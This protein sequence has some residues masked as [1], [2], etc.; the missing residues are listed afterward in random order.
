MN[1]QVNS[2]QTIGAAVAAAIAATA[3]VAPAGA[4]E[5][6]GS[7]AGRYVTGDFHNHSPCSDGQI[8]VQ[9][10]VNKSVDTYGLDWFVM[11]GHGGGGT[12]NCLL[13]EDETI[14]T[15][16]SNPYVPGQGPTTT[17]AN[18]IGIDKVKGD[19]AA[20]GFMFRWQSIQEFQYPVLEQMAAMKGKAIFIG[21]ESVVAGHE[22]S[23]V[24]VIDGQLPQGG[25]GN[26]TAM[27]QWEYCFDRADTD[28]SRG[29]GQ[30]WDCSVPGSELNADQDPT[31]AKLRNYNGKN[32]DS[33]T[34][35]HLKTVQG[36][37]WM[38][39]FHPRS[40]YYIPAHLER[41]GAFNPSSNRG[42]NVEHLRDFNNAAPDIAFGFEGGPGHQAS[43]SRGGYGGGAVGGG[44]YGG[45]GFYTAQVGGVWDALLGEGRNWF[46]FNNSDYHNR[47]SFGPDDP[48]T[49]NDQYPGEYNKTYVLARTGGAPLSPLAIIDGM[50]SGNAYYVNGDLIDRLSYV[51]CAINGNHVGPSQG[52]GKWPHEDQIARAAEDGA[53]FFNENC[54]Q[55]GEKLVVKPGQDLLVSVVLR[56]PEGANLSHY[57]F[58]NPSLMQVGISQ[59]L[60]MPVLDHVDLIGG[61]VTGYV[62]PSDLERYA[63]QI[64]TPA[65]TNP[66]TAVLAT[67]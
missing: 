44:A 10:L 31:A 23:D 36:I 37:K 55:Q 51:V 58:P 11:A 46:I 34:L 42:Y 60:N 16:P 18:S 5:G 61:K 32:Y 47:G 45:A 26:A 63:G 13:V 8:S 2:M 28:T 7:D 33:G 66:S 22:H 67:F 4:A 25:G 15:P 59:P 3:L 9:K 27:A 52:N 21:L 48:R 17:W 50:R 62:D 6:D 29:G 30:G 14:E 19:R 49:T 56:D 40:S 57:A 54:A 65:A 35:G 41:A 39:A 1:K 24:A 64:N 20:Q 53:G 43:G 38:A 12:R